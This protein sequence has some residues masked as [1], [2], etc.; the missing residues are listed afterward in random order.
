MHPT[1]K[2]YVL[3]GKNV[4]KTVLRI[5]LRGRSF[6]RS[7]VKGFEKFFTY[8]DTKGCGTKYCD[9]KYRDTL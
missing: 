8:C 3:T 1:I 7:K 2:F 5:G 4:I 6:Q 9:P